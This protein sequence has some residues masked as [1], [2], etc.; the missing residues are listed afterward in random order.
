MNHNQE[1]RLPSLGLALIPIIISV[2]IFIVGIGILKYP[3]EIMLVFS[4][5]IFSLFAI[6]NGNKW[7]TIITVMG[8]KIKKALPAILILLSIGLLIGSWIISG[9]IPYFI[10]YGLKIIDPNYLY[11]MAFIVTAIVSTCTGTSWGGSRDCRCCVDR[12]CPN[13]GSFLSYY[14]WCCRFRILFWR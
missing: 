11:L 6:I 4:G 12:H 5:V 7:D 8:S 9:T 10:Y 2:A 3:A 14:S 1:V 13:D